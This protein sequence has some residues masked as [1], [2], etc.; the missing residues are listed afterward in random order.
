MRSFTFFSAIILLL[1]VSVSLTGLLHPELYTLEKPSWYLQ[2]VGQDLVDLLLVTPVLGIASLYGS[3]GSA[4]AKKIWAGTMLYLVYT[5][6]IYCFDVH[7]N[8]LFLLYCALLGISVYGAL[9]YFISCAREPVDD[10][11]RGWLKLTGIYFG[12]VA[13][14]FCLL[15]LSE[16]VPS[17]MIGETPGS[18]KETGLLT[19]PVHVLDLSIVLPGI[20]VTGIGLVRGTKPSIMLAV[21]ILTFFVL[22]DLTIAVL[23]TIMFVQDAGGNAYVAIFMVLL[24]IFSGLLLIMGERG[25]Q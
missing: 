5:F 12:S 10:Y 13:V 2:S 16:I 22:M 14:L 17:I 15:W 11:S 19:N 3:K 24:A 25:K 8:R 4:T 23:S 6:V 20:F 1:L 18:L 21:P 9:D 7:F